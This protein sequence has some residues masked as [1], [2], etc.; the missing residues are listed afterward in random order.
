MKRLLILVDFIGPKKE[1]FAEGIAKGFPSSYQV[2]LARFS[3]LIFKIDGK[4]VSIQIEELRK[5]ITDFDL[6]YF[7]R[8][9][10]KFFS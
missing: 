2:S 10:T 8:A 6:V 3:D 1:L 7:R 4:S 5:R 9:G